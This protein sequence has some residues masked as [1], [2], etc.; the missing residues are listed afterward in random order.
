MVS[1]YG[2]T[3]CN[4]I[5]YRIMNRLRESQMISLIKN[6]KLRRLTELKQPLPQHN[7]IPIVNLTKY[8]VSTAEISQL[9]YSFI[10]KNKNQQKFLAANL[11]LIC[12]K[13]GK[14]IDQDMKKEFHEFLRGCTDIFNKNMS[15]TKDHTYNNLKGL[16]AFFYK[17][18]F[19][20]QQ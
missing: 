3:F 18:H 6:E 7:K 8:V 11:K 19:Y 15:N 4:I 13:V 17:Q 2:K 10:S 9:E 14:D 5:T 20:K 12:Q 1:N 16:H